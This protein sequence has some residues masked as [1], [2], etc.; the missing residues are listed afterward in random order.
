MYETKNKMSMGVIKTFQ[1][2]TSYGIQSQIVCKRLLPISIESFTSH[3]VHQISHYFDAAETP[4]Q[5]KQKFT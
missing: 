4:E 2:T 3:N 5:N 1:I